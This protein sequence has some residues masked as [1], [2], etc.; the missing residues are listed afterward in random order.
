[1]IGEEF[2]RKS[3]YDSAVY[4]THKEI[5][6]A[7]KATKKEYIIRGFIL[8]G[9]IW[10][11]KFEYDKAFLNYAKAD[12]ICSNDK[13]FETSPFMHEFIIIWDMPLELHMVMQNH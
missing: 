9:N 6:L 8:L 12:S 4:Y 2:K 13:V 10:Y 7:E 5:N 3:V 1:L 11:Q